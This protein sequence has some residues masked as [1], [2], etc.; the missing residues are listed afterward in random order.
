MA[1]NGARE[2]GE[3]SSLGPI[4]EHVAHVLGKAMEEA[5]PLL[6]PPSVRRMIGNGH[7]EDRKARASRVELGNRVPDT[8]EA[9]DSFTGAWHA[10][11]R[12]ARIV[13][14]RIVWPVDEDDLTG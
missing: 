5:L 3:S 6:R 4:A 14:P 8:E 7:H 10:Y 13:D 11:N 9:R 12:L 1:E 2:P